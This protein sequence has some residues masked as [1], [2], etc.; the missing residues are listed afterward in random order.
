MIHNFSAWK[1]DIDRWL[2]QRSGSSKKPKDILPTREE[3]IRLQRDMI[4]DASNILS[5]ADKL[6]ILVELRNS[7]KP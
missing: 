6:S 5:T 4:R 3:L 7:E 2:D 1:S